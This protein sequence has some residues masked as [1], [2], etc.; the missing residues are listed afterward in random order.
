MTPAGPFTFGIRAGRSHGKVRTVT[1]H[2]L[3]VA[4]SPTRSICLA[5][6]GG[7]AARRWMAEARASSGGIPQLS[8][9]MPGPLEPLVDGP[10]DGNWHE[11]E[12]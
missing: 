12:H 3:E 11:Q 7:E 8:Q 10:D 1:P 5:G 9:R 6:P 2:A 4:A